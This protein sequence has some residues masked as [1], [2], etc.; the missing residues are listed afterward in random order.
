MSERFASG[1]NALAECDVCGFQYRL[2]Q[3]KPL[4]I[5]AVVTGIKACPECWN[6]D[7]PQLML[8]TFPVNDPQAIRDPRADVTGYPERRARL[9]PADPIFAFGHVGEVAIVLTTTLTVTVATGTNV[10]GTGN[11]FYIDGVVSPTLTLFEGN[12]YKFDQSDG[13]NGPHPLRFS[14]T[15]NGTWGGG[16]EYP[17]GVTT[18]GAPGNPGAY[19]QIVVAAGAPTLHY[20]CTAHSGMGG[21]ANTPT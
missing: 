5:K 13:T 12:T 19:T 7:Q 18:N 9:Q 14:T 6:P 11:K 15:P 2:R 4:V 20:Y 3:L 10:Y 21:Q 16:V 17:T 1:Q 8:G